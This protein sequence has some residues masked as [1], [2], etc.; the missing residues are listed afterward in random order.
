MARNENPPFARGETFYNGETIDTNNLGGINLE[1]AEWV[2]EDVHASTGVARTGRPVRCRVVRNSSGVN[3]L[4]KRLV[5]FEAGALEFGSRVDGY[6]IAGA[7]NTPEAGYPLDE[8]LPAAG[9]PTNDLCWIVIEGPAK[10]M[11]SIADMASDLGI[12]GWS[13]AVTAATSQATTAG[14][15]IPQLLTGATAPLAANVQN[16]VGR[17]LSGAITTSTAADVVVDVGHW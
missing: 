3:L 4:P 6:A 16:R 12:G 13:V 10:V 17:A 2:F 14:R 11:T 8:Y 15:I 5:K 9:V 1:G 7:A